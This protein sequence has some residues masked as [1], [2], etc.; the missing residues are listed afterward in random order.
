MKTICEYC[1]AATFELEK[2]TINCCKEGEIFCHEVFKNYPDELKNSFTIDQNASNEQQKLSK[3]FLTMTRKVNQKFAFGSIS[4]TR[5]TFATTGPQTYVIQG[6][7]T[8]R[9]FTGAPEVNG[10]AAFGQLYM[11]GP[12]VA[13]SLNL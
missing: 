5:R 10:T 8:R 9:H 11:L 3:A 12:D 1:G 7:M 6:A 2:K 13:A 4:V